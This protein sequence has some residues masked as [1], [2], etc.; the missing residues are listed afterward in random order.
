MV[1]RIKH[2]SDTNERL[3]ESPLFSLK[4]M[5]FQT[6]LTDETKIEFLREELSSGRYEIQSTSLAAKLMEHVQAIEQ[7]ET[8]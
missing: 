8:V 4:K 3:D 1:E 2:H 6:T 5:L 7:A